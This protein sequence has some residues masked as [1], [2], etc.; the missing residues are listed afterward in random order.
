[1]TAANAETFDYGPDDFSRRLDV[2]DVADRKNQ[3]AANL[4]HGHG[5]FGA[6]GL[7]CHVGHLGDDILPD[8]AEYEHVNSVA[9]VRFGKCAPECPKPIEGKGRTLDAA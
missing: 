1:M 4:S 2:A 3:I 9:Q 6:F 8:S 7:E 5:P